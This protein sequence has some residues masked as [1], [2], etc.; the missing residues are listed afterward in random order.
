MNTQ[1]NT[2]YTEEDVSLKEIILTISDYTKEVWSRKFLVMFVTAISVIGFVVVAFLTRPT[3][4]G[5]L[6]F[7]VNEED[8]SGSNISGLLGQFGIG[9]STE[10]NLDKIL[11]LSKSRRISQNILFDSIS[12]NGKADMIAN[13][14][15]DYLE[16]EGEWGELS[17]LYKLLYGDDPLPLKGFRFKQVD[18]STF[19]AIENKAL[20]ALHIKLAGTPDGGKIGIV[21]TDYSE[22]SGIMKLIADTKRPELSIGLSKHLYEELSRYYI[23]KATEKHKNTFDIVKLKSDSI[24]AALNAAQYN[25]ASFNDKN[26]NIF[27]SKDKLTEQRY[28]IEIEKLMA[29]YAK[30]EENLQ[31]ADFTL[32]NK[33][34]YIDVIDEPILPLIANRPSL[35]QAI[36]K[37]LL[38]GLFLSL[39]YIVFRKILRDIM[40][41]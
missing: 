13:H 11:E 40:S 4:P 33:T 12:V 14:T 5:V 2:N 34:P 20:K 8:S 9:G 15:I 28:I 32:K 35:V 23:E 7:M 41:A 1:H 21:T 19:G 37:G 27:R 29:M 38:L 18:E 17:L 22:D 24:A 16:S 26:Q 10:Y 39:G 3:F 36:I 30:T 31:I 25:L 6:T